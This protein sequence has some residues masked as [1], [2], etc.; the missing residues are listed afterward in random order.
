MHQSSVNDLQV[1]RVSPATAR[2]G[3]VSAHAQDSRSNAVN[4]LTRSLS[5][6]LTRS[7]ALL[8]AR[9]LERGLYLAEAHHAVARQSGPTSR[10]AGRKSKKREENWGWYL[11][12]AKWHGTE[13][14][15]RQART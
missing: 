11:L 12:V 15:G 6:L 5:C 1:F 2:K 14:S 13:E 8:L 3:K 9:S 7:L 10:S 4:S